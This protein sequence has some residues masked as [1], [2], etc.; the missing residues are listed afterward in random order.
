VNS[1]HPDADQKKQE[2]KKGKEGKEIEKGRG[3]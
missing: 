2:R 3:T 1:G